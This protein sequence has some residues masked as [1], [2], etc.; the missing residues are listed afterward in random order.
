MG[1][2]KISLAQEALADAAPP[3]PTAAISTS[4]VAPA[5]Q[6]VA[7]V[8][9]MATP[10]AQP[11]TAAPAA[12]TDYMTLTLKPGEGREIKLEMRKGSTASYEWTATG[13]VNHDTHGET[14]NAAQGDFH[15]YSK[16]KQVKGDAGEITALFDGTHGW[17]WRN[18]TNSEVTVSLKTSGDYL[19]V[20]K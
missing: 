5:P 3:Q 13:P 17:F 4:V 19:S 10:T 6:P 12:K 18:R 9:P 16:A 2:L 20:K 8:Q 7:Q 15:S 1:E 11:T 14:Y